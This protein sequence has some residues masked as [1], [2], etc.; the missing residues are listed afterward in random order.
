MLHTTA[1]VSALIRAGRR[2][3]LAGEETLLRALPRGIWIAG[4]IPYFMAHGGGCVARDRIFVTELPP[5]VQALKI[6]A[7][8]PQSLP[9]IVGEAPEGGFTVLVMPAASPVLLEYAQHGPDYPGL[10][11][12]PIVGWIAGVHLEDLGRVPPMVFDGRSGEA[13]S[14][15][16]VAMHCTLTPGVK[17]QVGIVNVFRPGNGD[18]L[19]FPAD[20]FQASTCWVGGRQR[21]LAAY[22][23]ESGI[24]TRLPL[25]ANY[26]GAMVNVSIQSV[27][28]EADR[29]TFYGPVF[30]GVVYRMAAPLGDYLADFR[31]ALPS[32]LA[33]VFSCNCILNYLHSS[34]EGRLTPGMFG[35]FTFGEIAYQLLNQTLVYLTLQRD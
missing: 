31:A 35:P 14:D 29:V 21:S 8:G 5:E 13:Y 22:L 4:T 12:K 30:E 26:A 34:L 9:G 15:R 7:Y 6:A 16:A 32:G 33:P 10:F 23:A 20:G 18:P 2:L 25:V 28:P 19:S 11:L 17:A 1:E 24:D 3:L 27:D